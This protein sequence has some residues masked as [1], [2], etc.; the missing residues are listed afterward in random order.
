MAVSRITPA[1]WTQSSGASS[2]SRVY[3]DGW[4]Q[5]IGEGGGGI[6]GVLAA[7]QA[8]DALAAAGAVAIAGA[9]AATQAADTL[10]SAGSVLVSGTI[11]VTQADDTFSGTSGTAVLGALAATQEPDALASAGTV[12]VSGTIAVTQAGDTLAS[13]GAVAISGV[14]AVT[15]A[16]D[17]FSGSD[18][19]VEI[20]GTLS[21]TQSADTFFGEASEYEEP[22]EGDMT[23]AE[24]VSAVKAWLHRSDLDA[25]IPDFIRFGEARLNRLIKLSLMLEITQIVPSSDVNYVTLPLR[26][27]STVS[28]VD[29]QG[30]ELREISPEEL[31][32]MAAT[33]A[34][35]RPRY[36]CITSRLNFERKAN[37]VYAYSLI[38]RKRLNML[39]DG[40]NPISEAYPDLYLYSA[41]LVSAPFIGDD[42]RAALWGELLSSAINEANSSV[43]SNLV[44]RPDLS[45]LYG[46]G[47]Y[48]IT[49]G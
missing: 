45:V 1:G 42:G 5:I 18:S 28:L 32:K 24:I 13:S 33:S 12:L 16:G 29:D 4:L 43:R 30:I 26:Y 35:G 31:S 36:Y 27:L 40:T 22:P 48:D 8:G 46:A 9:L 39:A 25:R 6:S 19:A 11:A 47:G 49:A 38:Y 17:T 7:V 2:V 14:L 34:A 3:P 20:T 37:G 21:V 10:A 41:L 15:Q 23:Y 44:M